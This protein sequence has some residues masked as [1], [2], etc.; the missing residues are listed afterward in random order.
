MHV[1]EPEVKDKGVEPWEL[2]ENNQCC[3]TADDVEKVGKGDKEVLEM[4]IKLAREV[5]WDIP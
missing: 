4:L 2:K 1:K 5:D 3:L